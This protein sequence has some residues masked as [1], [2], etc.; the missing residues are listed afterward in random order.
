MSSVVVSFDTGASSSADSGSLEVVAPQGE[1][2]VIKV[3]GGLPIAIIGGSLDDRVTLGA[4]DAT[5]L[6]QDGDDSIE[7]AIGDDTLMGGDGDD[8]LMGGI[9]ADFIFGGDGNDLIKGD[10]PG[11]DADE[12]SLGDLIE[13]GA[14]DDV[15]EFVAGEFESGAIDRIVDFKDGADLIRIEGVSD[16]VA[17]DSGTGILSIDG[18]DAIAINKGLEDIKIEKEEGTNTWEVF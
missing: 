17:Y 3:K 13:G 9:G 14:G 8:T 18:K 2:N 15:F 6:G 12:H 11:M 4:G 16:N 1:A 5:V 10:L 7:G